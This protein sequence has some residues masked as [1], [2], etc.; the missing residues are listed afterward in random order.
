[1]TLAELSRKQGDIIAC[2]Y[3]GL[4]QE[5]AVIAD[6]PETTLRVP[7]RN[8]GDS[9]FFSRKNPN[10]PKLSEKNGKDVTSIR[11]CLFVI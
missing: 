8:G 2:N 4:R 7:W 5:G 9:V 10:F 6:P 11:Q 1:M 3:Q